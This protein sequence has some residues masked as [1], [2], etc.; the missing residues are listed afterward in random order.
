MVPIPTAKARADLKQLL[1]KVIP[2]RIKRQTA[3]RRPNLEMRRKDLFVPICLSI[4][5]DTMELV[6]IAQVS[7]SVNNYSERFRSL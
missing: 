7:T 1:G 2:E 4:G 3:C 6:P 5:P